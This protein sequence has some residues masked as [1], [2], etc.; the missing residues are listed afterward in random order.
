MLLCVRVNESETC[1]TM[2]NKSV[3][4]QT[5]DLVLGC[6]NKSL[7]S[8]MLLY[9]YYGNKYVSSAVSDADHHKIIG[10][11]PDFF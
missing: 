1:A 5:S 11:T 10:K 3:C 6:F 7:E 9:S 8:C 4:Q 2:N